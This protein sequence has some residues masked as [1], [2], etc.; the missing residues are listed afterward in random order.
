[1]NPG[2]DKKILWGVIQALLA[3]VLLMTGG[4]DALQ[5]CSI[6]AALP[7]TVIMLLC[8]VCLFKALLQE[9]PKPEELSKSAELEK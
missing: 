9:K 6:V 5:T 2:N 1:M 4:L 7:L 8:A 3:L